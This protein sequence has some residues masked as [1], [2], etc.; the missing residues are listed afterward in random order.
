MSAAARL[1]ATA[2]WMLAQ[3]A[4]RAA[5]GL[6]HHHISEQTLATQ[7]VV[8]PGGLHLRTHRPPSETRYGGPRGDIYGLSAA[9]RRRLLEVLMRTSWESY[10]FAF[11][12]LTYHFGYDPSPDQWHSHLHHFL[13]ALGREWGDTV[14]G[15]LWI[16]EFQQR[17]APH[18]HLI[19]QADRP[20]G[21]PFRAWV[22]DR[23]NRI[24]EPG[25][26]VHAKA[27]TSCDDVVLTEDG[28]TR[29]LM[30]YLAKYIGKAGQKQRIDRATG[31]VLPTGRMWGKTLTYLLYEE[32]VISLDARGRAVLARRL[33]RWGRA[34]PYLHA[35]GRRSGGALIFC[36]SS[37]AL[38]LLRGLFPEDEPP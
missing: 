9:S 27:G 12:T 18:F 21:R 16:L 3:E 30:R 13:V 10:S 25:D 19:V 28:G 29:Q 15:W 32:A 4:R 14:K 37:A 24:A 23:W 33:R 26:E 31:E 38:Q 35:I 22:A 34:S 1:D 7:A 6:V 8:C 36:S 20:L 2:N 17:G 11:A 5:R